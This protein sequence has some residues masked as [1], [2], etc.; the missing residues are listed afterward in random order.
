MVPIST[1]EFKSTMVLT[2]LVAL[3]ILS[4]PDIIMLLIRY[5]CINGTLD[6]FKIGVALIYIARVC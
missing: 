3:M 1:L 2:T 5:H 4:T 6:Y